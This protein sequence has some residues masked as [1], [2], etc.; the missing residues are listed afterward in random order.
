MR[1][2][3]WFLLCWLLAG[4]P[5]TANSVIISPT[6]L[7]L[8]T[9]SHRVAQL[10]VTNNSTQRLPLEALVMNL[11]FQ[12]DGNYE[13][14]VASDSP[15]KIFP[16]AAILA[17]GSKQTFRVQWLTDSSLDE[18]KSYF[19]R[20]AQLQLAKNNYAPV[21]QSGI[22]SGVSVQVNYNALIHVYN[23]AQEP[24]VLLIVDDDG[25]GIL[26]NKGTRFTYSS[27]LHFNGIAAE[28]QEAVLS[29]IGDIFI[30]PN[31]SRDIIVGR[32][33]PAGEY[34]GQER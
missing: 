23:S 18:S 34:H 8:N 19:V 25:Q 9:Q 10:V 24:G 2:V 21:N 30:P 17:P 15:L 20:F 12:D 4:Y 1:R 28:T 13:T 22:S 32:L 5:L 27:L 16:P 29:A 3:K 14:Q 33:L 7:T 6:V 26:K 31:S 11:V